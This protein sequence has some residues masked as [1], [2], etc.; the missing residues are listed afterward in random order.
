[1]T[2]RDAAVHGSRRGAK[3]PADLSRFEPPVIVGA[4]AFEPDRDWLPGE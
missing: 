1:V 3:T 2:P 4:L